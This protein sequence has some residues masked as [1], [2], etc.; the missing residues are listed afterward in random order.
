M[1]ELPRAESRNKDAP[2]VPP[3]ILVGAKVED[4]GRF[5]I[6]HVIVKQ[7]SHLFSVAT[8]HDELHSRVANDGSVGQHVSKL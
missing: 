1:V 3:A 4:L 8:E 5:G 2:N 6:V 7:Q